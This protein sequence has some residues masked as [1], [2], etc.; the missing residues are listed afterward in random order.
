MM[1]RLPIEINLRAGTTFLG[2][3]ELNILGTY[4][5]ALPVGSRNN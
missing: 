1:T 2:L 4:Q 3:I 5:A